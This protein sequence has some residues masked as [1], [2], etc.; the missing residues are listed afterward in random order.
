MIL[1]GN[2]LLITRDEKNT[3]LD[4]GCVAVEG[5]EIVNVASTEEMKTQY[6]DAEFIDAK[7]GVIMP[8]LINTHNH[9]YSTF[10]RGLSI[11][12]F[13]PQNFMDIL[14]GQWWTIDRNLT[15]EDNKYSAYDT[16]IDCIK[17]GVTT[18]VDH[19]ASYGEI[20]DSLFTIADVAKELGVR[21]SLC[22]EVSDRDGADKMKAAVKENI[23]FI[24][25]AHEDKTGMVHGMLGLHA[26]FTLTDETL[27]YCNA[28]KPDYAGYHVHV[29]EGLDDVYDSLEKYGK[30]VVNRLFDKNI[31]GENT[32]AVHCI[33]INGEEMAILKDTN[34]MVVHNPESNM[35]NAVGC[36]PVLELVKRGIL[37][38]LGTDGY[39]N[40]MIESYKVANILHKHFNCDPNVAWGEIPQMLFNNNPAIAKRLFGK[41]L[42]VLAPGAAADIIIT[43]YN[44]TTPMNADNY[45]SHILFGMC[46]RSVITTMI[47][48]KVLMKD[49][50]LLNIDEEAILA[51][52]REAAKKLADRINHR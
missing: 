51:K 16:Y 35:G 8:G 29:A 26:A 37:I 5:N 48:G 33:H 30:R 2:G 41:T 40:D 24:K 45:N 3:Y 18:V 32:I 49:R 36:P 52:S 43:D 10:A 15:N 22:Y 44:P 12:G 34:T 1:I 19:H 13:N 6:P 28:E 25:A 14:D 50:E 21:T 31:L 38:G 11:E 46:G 23:D 42:G 9:I 39:T 17:Q 27:D 47:N 4:N 20:K 7:G